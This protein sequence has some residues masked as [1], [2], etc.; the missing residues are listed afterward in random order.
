MT[1]TAYSGHS[2]ILNS[3]AGLPTGYV[4][5]SVES[6]CKKLTFGET[7]SKSSFPY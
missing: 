7:R 4:P 6:G 2:E 1:K 5:V 3:I